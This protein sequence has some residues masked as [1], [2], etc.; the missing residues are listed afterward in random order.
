[1]PTEWEQ[2]ITD[3][4]HAA[5][6]GRIFLDHEDAPDEVR[7]TIDEFILDSLYKTSTEN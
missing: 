7:K 3:V 1:M 2:L 5:R 6:G 4:S